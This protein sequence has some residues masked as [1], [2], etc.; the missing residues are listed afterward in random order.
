MSV[1]E[2][3]SIYVLIPLAFGL[4]VVLLIAGPK[5]ARRPRYRVGR[6]WN[7]EPLFWSANPVGTG[8]PPGRTDDPT[9]TTGRGGARGN[10]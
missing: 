5:L 2:T 4:L 8:L 9:A 3:V 6:P 1:L 7:H 10:W